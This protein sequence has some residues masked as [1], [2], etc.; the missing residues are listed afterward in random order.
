M[1]KNAMLTAESMSDFDST[2]KAEFYDA[3]GF[4][5]ADKANKDKLKNPQPVKE[6][7]Q[8]GKPTCQ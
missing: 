5:V 3:D 6:L 4:G 1:E 7:A 2:K 8:E